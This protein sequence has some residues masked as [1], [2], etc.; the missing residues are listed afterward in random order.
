MLI[1]GVILAGGRSSRM[2]EDKAGL[3]LGGTS[4]LERTTALLKDAGANLVLVSGRPQL[5][6]GFADLYPNCGPPGAVL[7]TLHWLR[8]QHGLDGSLLLFLPV[9]MPLL[10]TSTLVDLIDASRSVHACH[11]ERQVFPCTMKATETLYGHLQQ[12]FQRGQEPGGRRS[13]KAIL[14]WQDARILPVDDALEAQFLNANTP[15]DWARVQLHLHRH[16]RG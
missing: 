8:Q 7:S 10:T 5:T 15:E 4:L 3:Q 11:Y 12:E 6:D 2:G 13:M 9:D 16:S 14:A 1:F